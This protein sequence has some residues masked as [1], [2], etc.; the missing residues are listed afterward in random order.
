MF[1]VFLNLKEMNLTLRYRD[2]ADRPPP[3]RGRAALLEAFKSRLTKP[4]DD[5]P[6]LQQEEAPKP[7]GRAS[8]I[9]RMKELKIGSATVPSSE[10]VTSTRIQQ[11][12]KVEDLTPRESESKPEL[13][14]C[15][16]KG[17]LLLKRGHIS[18]PYLLC[19]IILCIFRYFWNIYTCYCKLYTVINRK[20]QRCI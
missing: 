14:I 18:V 1:S 20:K 15:S 6:A 8:L 19:Y 3:P 11:S 16:F 2:M 12:V 4:G 5:K 9:A 7:R 17:N 13:P 10:P